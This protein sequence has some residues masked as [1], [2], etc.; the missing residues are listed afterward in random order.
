M[1]INIA[2]Y[3]LQNHDL[4]ISNSLRIWTVVSSLINNILWGNVTQLFTKGIVDGGWNETWAKILKPKIL[5]LIN[6]ALFSIS[7]INLFRLKKYRTDIQTVVLWWSKADGC[8][9]TLHL[10]SFYRN[11]QAKYRIRF[12]KL[13]LL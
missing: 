11:A 10:V 13:M 2:Y 4:K 7:N 6:F 12:F 8:I 9:Y 5:S 1:Y 3:G